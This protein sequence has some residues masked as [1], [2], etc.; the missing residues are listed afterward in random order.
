MNKNY[1]SYDY[2]KPAQSP[3]STS[4]S[5]DPSPKKDTNYTYTPYSQ[6]GQSGDKKS[7]YQG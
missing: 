6:T 5:Y 3:P 4:Y 1:P 7:A 2:S